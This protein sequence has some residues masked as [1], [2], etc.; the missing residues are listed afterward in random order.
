MGGPQ[1]H[2][3]LFRHGIRKGLPTIRNLVVKILK[4]RAHSLRFSAV[5]MTERAT[6]LR[7]TAQAPQSSV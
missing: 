4:M 1:D 7:D 5:W 2:A 3:K 6:K